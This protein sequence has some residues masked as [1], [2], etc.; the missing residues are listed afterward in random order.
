MFTNTIL[1]MDEVSE[2]KSQIQGRQK[3]TRHVKFLIGMISAL[4]NIFAIGV[5]YD[6]RVKTVAMLKSYIS[7]D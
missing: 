4:P 7:Y 3:K 2:Q 6:T 1:K 5:I